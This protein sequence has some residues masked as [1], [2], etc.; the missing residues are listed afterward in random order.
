MFEMKAI[1]YKTIYIKTN[2]RY[3]RDNLSFKV[4]ILKTVM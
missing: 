1:L 4:I 3:T 2:Y